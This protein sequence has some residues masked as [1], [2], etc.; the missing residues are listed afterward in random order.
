MVDFKV[1]DVPGM[2]SVSVTSYDVNNNEIPDDGAWHRHLSTGQY[3]FA[4]LLVAK[5]LVPG[6]AS[7]E[8]SPSLV[9]YWSELNGVGQ[10]FVKAAYD[11]WLKS[12]DDPR[13]TEAVMIKKLERRWQKFTAQREAAHVSQGSKA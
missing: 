8:R 7:V 4:E 5:G 12:V 10:A 1:I 9:I 13:T 6:R 2:L 3:V 11:K